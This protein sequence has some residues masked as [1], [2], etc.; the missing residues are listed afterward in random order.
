M[1]A[2]TLDAPQAPSGSPSPSKAKGGLLDPGMLVRSLPNA[3]RKL[4]PR[5]LWR[6]PVMFIV[7]IGALWSTVLAVV[8]P[9]WFGWQRRVQR[10]RRHHSR[11]RAAYPGRD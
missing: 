4:D 9:S 1:S 7:E 6:N 3:L 5:S 2:P 10:W 8:D 11:D